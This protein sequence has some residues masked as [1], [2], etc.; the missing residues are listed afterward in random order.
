M[1]GDTRE[2]KRLQSMYLAGKV[3]GAKWDLWRELGGVEHRES[4]PWWKELQGIE[5]V[6][7]D[8]TN[9]SE[10]LWGGGM[11]LDAIGNTDLKESVKE[12]ATDQIRRCAFLLAYLDKP[13][14]FGSIA[15]IAYGAALGKRCY[16]VVLV[17]EQDE[18]SHVDEGGRE[19]VTWPW[20]DMKDAY[21]FVSCFP[22]VHS[23]VVQSFEEAKDAVRGYVLRGKS[24]LLKRTLEER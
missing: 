18:V 14:S 20:E 7:S 16:V 22:G 6:A 5:V 17:P 8:G 23:I 15:E 10:H 12:Y 19:Y 9:H 11:S 1:G 24:Q 13:D 3:D 21:W 4:H 2:L